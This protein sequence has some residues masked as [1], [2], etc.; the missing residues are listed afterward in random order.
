MEENGKAN[1]KEGAE[2]SATPDLGKFKSVDALLRAYGELE[3]EF[4]RRSQR[5]KELEEKSE[6]NGNGVSQNGAPHDSGE[7]YRAVMENEEVRAR[8]LGD[9]LSSLKGVPLMA[10][11]GTGVTAPAKRPSSIF[12]AGNFALDYLKNKN[13]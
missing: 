12:E 2:Q 4:T 13:N 7:L 5:L 6:P 1:S 10:G 11:S 3:S 8:V 9:Y